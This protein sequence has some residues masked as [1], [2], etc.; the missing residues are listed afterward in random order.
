MLKDGGHQFSI[1]GQLRS[2]AGSIA[3]ESGDNLGSQEVGGFKIGPAAALKC[4]ECMGSA[5]DIKTMVL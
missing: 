4:R 2:F 5:Q 1:N 3:F